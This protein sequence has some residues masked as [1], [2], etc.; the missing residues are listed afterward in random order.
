MIRRSMRCDKPEAGPRRLFHAQLAAWGGPA[1]RRQRLVIGPSL[2]GVMNRVDVA[3]RFQRQVGES[4]AATAPAVQVQA[5]A[6]F[7]GVRHVCVAR[8]HDVGVGPGR[9]S[10]RPGLKAA[11]AGLRRDHGARLVERVQALIQAV[12]A[13]A[14]EAPVD[15]GVS[16][17]CLP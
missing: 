17:A 13:R 9:D 10:H 4:P 6:V 14:P 11:A 12:T 5:R 16:L 15:L 7:G 2:P 3:A 1:S 8:H